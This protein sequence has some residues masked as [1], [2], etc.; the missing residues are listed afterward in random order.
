MDE[1]LGLSWNRAV[2]DCGVWGCKVLVIWL[3]IRKGGKGKGKKG[4][5][6]MGRGRKGKMRW[7]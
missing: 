7:K 3:I 2:A 6:E 5:M 1:C 4:L